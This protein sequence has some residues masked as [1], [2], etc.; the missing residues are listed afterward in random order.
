MITK[1]FNAVVA[2]LVVGVFV[3]LVVLVFVA[4]YPF[5]AELVEKVSR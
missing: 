2:A 4:G 5:L 1:I 3:A